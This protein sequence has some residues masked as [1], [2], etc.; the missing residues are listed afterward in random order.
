[1]PIVSVVVPVY[2]VEKYIDR[3]VQSIR[4]QS[5]R[6]IEIILVDDGSPDKCPELCD[7]YAAVDSRI[8]VVHKANGGLSSARNAGMRIA[9]GEYIGFVDSDDSIQ[10]TMFE[11]MVNIIQGKDLDFV[12]SDYNRILKSG[13]SFLKTLEISGG[14]YEKEDIER[15]IYPS[16]IMGENIDYGYLLS[17][18]HCLY[19]L[20]FLRTNH[21]EFDEEVKWS[22]DNIFSAIVG[23]CAK[24]FYYLKGQGLYNYYQNDGSI[25]TSYKKESWKVYCKMNKHLHAYFDYVE[26]YDFSKQLKLHLIYYACNCLGQVSNLPYK[27]RKAE[28]QKILQ[29]KELVEAFDKLIFNNISIKLKIQLHLMKKQNWRLIDYIVMRRKKKV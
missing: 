23:Y 8:K 13:K 21:I 25:T 2:K 3:C 11:T 6:D 1:M 20:N 9:S 15:E 27:E 26:D 5:L 17:V 14:L 28:I 19:N 24:R 22:E 12:M 29:T 10:H 18:W 16:L 7:Q 4:K